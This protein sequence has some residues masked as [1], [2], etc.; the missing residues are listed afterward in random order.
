MDSGKLPIIVLPPSGSSV[1]LI[2]KNVNDKKLK[3]GNRKA[4]RKNCFEKFN[5]AS[6]F[7]KVILA[8]GIIIVVFLDND[9]IQS[10]SQLCGITNARNLSEA[11]IPDETP[12]PGLRGAEVAESNEKSDNESTHATIIE[13]SNKSESNN[14]DLDA[15]KEGENEQ[16]NMSKDN[17]NHDLQ[18][19]N[20]YSSQAE[21]TDYSKLNETQ[22]SDEKKYDE[23]SY[24]PNGP[25]A[26]DIEHAL[27]IMPNDSMIRSFLHTSLTIPP[28]DEIE[29]PYREKTQDDV[30]SLQ[31][32]Q[33]IDYM[34]SVV[35][36]MN[37]LYEPKTSE[38]SP[39]SE[40][41][42]D[43]QPADS[44]PTTYEQTTD[45]EPTTHEQATDSEPTT[46]EQ[47]TDSEPITHEQTADSETTKDGQTTDSEP[48]KPE[49]DEY[50]AL[51]N[52]MNLE[53]KMYPKPQ[54]TE[55]A[56]LKYDYNLDIIGNHELDAMFNDP[57][58]H[59]GARSKTDKDPSCNEREALNG[60]GEANDLYKNQTSKNP[61]GFNS[62]FHGNENIN[63]EMWGGAGP[64]SMNRSQGM[65]SWEYPSTRNHGM[66]S[67]QYPSMDKSQGMNSWEYPSTRN[68]GMNSA[69]YPSMDKSQGMNSWEYPSTRNQGMKSAQYPSMNINEEMFGRQII[70]ELQSHNGSAMDEPMWAG[71]KKSHRPIPRKQAG[72]H[73]SGYEGFSHESYSSD[74]DEMNDR[75]D[76]LEKPS[77][78]SARSRSRNLM[79]SYNYMDGPSSGSQSKQTMSSLRASDPYKAN[80]EES[81]DDEPISSI[82]RDYLKSN[83]KNKTALGNASS[84]STQN[85]DNRFNQ[86]NQM[87]TQSPTN[88]NHGTV[89]IRGNQEV[90]EFNPNQSKSAEVQIKEMDSHISQKLSNLDVNA[91]IAQL[92]NIWSEF[93]AAETKK[94]LMT[95]EYALQYSIYLQK[96]NNL[97]PES[98]TKAWWKV[99][100]SMGNKF[101]KYEKKHVEELKELIKES[102][103]MAL[104]FVRFI[105]QKREIWK[106]IQMELKNTW[107]G[108]L[109]YKMNKYGAQDN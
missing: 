24:D 13:D 36:E 70:E 22:K 59:N 40:T 32:S 15:T 39:D 92:H 102:N 67:A 61:T 63:M 48:S 80:A 56:P 72:A 47:A 57:Q 86:Q 9:N 90:S 88:N 42:K 97:S 73:F 1:S 38:Q 6:T 79:N 49:H 105:I 91:T 108:A 60:W 95:Q 100:Y 14:A 66:N 78:I 25:F 81:D 89:A 35:H 43:E 41:T 19:N 94:F 4:Y 68:H 52:K 37:K 8:F 104:D 55:L 75:V 3:R 17:A 58:P 93:I 96:R 76:M 109:T 51:H 101:I 54:Q 21:H 74:D 82:A 29:D 69:Q 77:S 98:R 62:N 30:E 27:N 31:F 53:Y 28:D 50:A 10:S 45:S 7:Y 34:K 5:L 106:K 65:N 20:F 103:S 23:E 99:H 85:A 107:L 71:L 87:N 26:A 33:W 18:E 84:Q 44:E 46:H 12:S 16:A 11:V 64:S 83:A 2:K